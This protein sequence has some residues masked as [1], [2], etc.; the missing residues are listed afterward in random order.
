MMIKNFPIDSVRALFP[1]LDRKHNGMDVA[2]FD[3]PGGA[4]FLRASIDAMRGYMEG[5]AANLGAPTPTSLSTAEIVERTKSDILDLFGAGDIAKISFGPNATTMMFHISRAISRDWSKGDEIILTEMDHYSNVDSW[6]TA[7]EDKGVTVRWL[8]L[9]PETMQL[10]LEKLPDLLSTRTRLVAVGM[11]SNCIGTITD[12][13]QVAR[14]AKAVGALVAVDA[15]HAIPHVHVDMQEIGADILFSSAY[16]FFAAHVGMAVVRDE[17][18]A[19]IRPYRVGS[20]PASSM[21]ELG[22]QNYEGI[23]AIS[24]AISFIEGLGH[25][26]TKKD[27]IASG[28][29]AIEHHENALAERIRTFLSAASGIKLYQAAA[30]VPKTPTI[31]FTA[32]GISPRSFCQKL[33]D[34]HAIFAAD[35]LFHAYSLGKRLGIQ[36]S[37]GFIR[38]GLAPYNT[39]QEVERFI[40]AVE[41]IMHNR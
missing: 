35:G 4:Q 27:R 21:F 17:V 41:Q 16:K 12:V 39:D 40:A 38:V 10:E 2:Y 20:A 18:L 1:S 15:V 30:D 7:A 29:L 13:A 24:S 32:Q 31:A 11:A 19:G 28:Y 33:S 34:D 5:G 22:T 14:Q 37:G 6:L 36:D 8:P 9:N 23:A 3:G 25:G 26:D